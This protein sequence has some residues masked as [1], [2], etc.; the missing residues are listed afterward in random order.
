MQHECGVFGVYNTTEPAHKA[1]HALYALQHRGQESSG[2]YVSDSENFQGYKNH[3]LVLQ[4]FDDERLNDLDSTNPCHA[5]GQVSASGSTNIEINSIQPMFFKHMRA[6]F[7]LCASGSLLNQ[8][9][10]NRSLQEEGAIFQSS[11]ICET[12]T[13]LLVRNKETF[14]PALKQSLAELVGSYC[15]IILRKNRLYAMR[16]PYGFMPLC[17]GKLGDSYIVASESCALDALGAE[18]IRDVEAGEIIEINQEGIFSHRFTDR[19]KPAFCL[20]EYVYFA[21]PDSIINGINVHKARY[22]CGVELA[23]ESTADCDLVIGVPDSSLSAAQGFAQEANLP[24]HSGLIKNKYSGRSFIEPMAKKRKMVVSMKLS[25]IRYLIE[26]KSITLI[27]DSIVRGTTMRHL[28]SMLR[29]Y[30]AKEVHIRIASPKMLG[31]CF[32]GVDFSSYEEL[33]GAH[34]SVDEICKELGADSL[35]FLSLPGLCKAVGIEENAVCGACYTE[36]Y[37]TSLH[38]YEAYVREI[39]SKLPAERKY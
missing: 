9:S 5:L 37:P 33:I 23:K 39:Q 18:F 19:A 4:V 29:D 8:E 17:L 15:F 34:K 38:D 24:M 27:D 36:K 26:N 25:P 12:L 1:F 6:E 28:V 3:G 22:N 2:I 31:P 16:D 7:A 30:G 21:R 13:H 14:L 32:Y 11:S 20:M 10:L 35:K